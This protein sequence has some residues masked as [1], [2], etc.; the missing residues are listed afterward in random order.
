MLRELI[1]IF[2]RGCKL[3]CPCCRHG[4]LFKSAMRVH[5]RCSG[6][7]ELFEREPG[8]WFGAVYVNLGLTFG[9][10]VAGYTL[11][12][13][14][15]SVTTSEQIAIW[16]SVAALGPFFFCRLSKGLW[17]S[18]VF[19]GEGLYIPWPNPQGTMKRPTVHAASRYGRNRAVRRKASGDRESSASPQETHSPLRSQLVLVLSQSSA[20]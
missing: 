7:G 12:Q 14:F 19:F 5:A 18:V 9:V 16:T 2:I 15:T 17:I 20:S 1:G 6:C 10:T 11:T 4:R 3:R 13:A 8:L